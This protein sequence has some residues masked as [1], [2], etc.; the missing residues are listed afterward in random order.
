M[1]QQIMCLEI[2]HF[3]SPRYVA[4]YYFNWIEFIFIDF[5]CIDKWWIY[6]KLLSY[7]LV[8]YYQYDD[9]AISMLYNLN[10]PGAHGQNKTYYFTIIIYWIKIILLCENLNFIY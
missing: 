9:L 10:Q 3:S 8:F 4:P 6:F 7:N 5:L 2:E 1:S